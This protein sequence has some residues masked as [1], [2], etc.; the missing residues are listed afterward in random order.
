[1]SKQYRKHKV[2]KSKRHNKPDSRDTV[3]ESMA[4]A[5]GTDEY[6]PQIGDSVTHKLHTT[7]GVGKVTS[8]VLPSGSTAVYWPRTD[9]TTVQGFHTLIEKKVHQSRTPEPHVAAVGVHEANQ[10]I[11]LSDGAITDKNVYESMP[12]DGIRRTDP[13]LKFGAATSV[14]HQ[15]ETKRGRRD[16]SKAENASIRENRYA[17]ALGD[18]VLHAHHKVFGSGRIVKRRDQGNEYRWDVSWSDGRIRTHGADYLVSLDKNPAQSIRKEA[19]QTKEPNPNKAWRKHKSNKRFFGDAAGAVYCAE[20]EVVLPGGGYGEPGDSR[21]WCHICYRAR[22]ENR[23]HIVAPSLRQADTNVRTKMSTAKQLRIIAE[24]STTKG[25]TSNPSMRDLSFHDAG[26]MIDS[27]QQL[28]DV[29]PPTGPYTISTLQ[30]RVISD[31][32]RRVGKPFMYA[33]ALSVDEAA[34]IIRKL[35]QEHDEARGFSC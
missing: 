32:E 9:Q 1:M 31:L 35:Q 17:F 7:Y 29:T 8:S 34:G 11:M 5:M 16:R 27:W 4:K 30:R 24:L 26:V 25:V 6:V 13:H 21:R 12:K 33:V 19:E 15:K 14:S 22:R 20:C 2:K 28:P 3:E 23:G 10:Q 18:R